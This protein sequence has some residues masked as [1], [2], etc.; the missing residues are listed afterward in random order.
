MYFDRIP[1]EKHLYI[2]PNADHTLL[3]GIISVVSN[4]AAFINSVNSRIPEVRPTFKS[5][6]D[7]DNG[8]LTVVVPRHQVQPKEVN[9]RYAQTLKENGRMDFRWVIKSQDITKPNI[10]VDPFSPF[11]VIQRLLDLLGFGKSCPLPFLPTPKVLQDKLNQFVGDLHAQDGDL[12][13]QPIFWHSE[14]LES[15]GKDKHGQ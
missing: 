3:T 13:V 6:V 14:T 15:S 1:G 8:E 5:F 9:L 12:C 4:I 7:E 11:N 10:D 2:V